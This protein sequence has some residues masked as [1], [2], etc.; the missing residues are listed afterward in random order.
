[1]GNSI[2]ARPEW[3]AVHPEAMRAFV[4][5]AIFAVKKSIADPAGAIAALKKY[6]S[7]VND[8]LELESLGFSNTK[9]I[10]T[11]NVKKNGIS[12]FSAQRLDQVLAQIS[13]ALGIAK[14]ARDEVWTPAYL[15]SSQALMLQ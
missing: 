6:N 14:P 3:L 1:M 12:S 9:A 5:C 7:L 4:K 2:I 8:K 11:D 10:L 15:P 13:D